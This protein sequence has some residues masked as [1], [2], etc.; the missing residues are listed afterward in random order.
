MRHRSGPSLLAVLTLALAASAAA[1]QQPPA[2][3]DAGAAPQADLG[4]INKQLTNPVSS[5]WSITFQQNNFRIDP[6]LGQEERWSSNLLFQPVLPIGITEEWNLVTRPVVP[7]FVSQPHPEGGDPTDVGRSTNFGDITLMQLVSPG[8]QLAGGWLLGLGPSWIF[9]SAGSNWTGSGRWQLGPAALAGYLSDKWILGA[10]LQN[11]WSFAGP[12]SR[13][14]VRSMNLQ[15]IASYFLPDA[16]S[17]GYS[18]NILANWNNAGSDTFTVPIGVSIA[19]VVK[20]GKLPVRFAL[21]GQWMPIQPDAYGQKWN[22]QLVVAPVL[23]KLV[24]G[25]LSEPSGMSFGLHEAAPR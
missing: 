19:K 5:L 11:W 25:Y 14:S 2:D 18:G 15:P 22:L 17:I 23:P 1:E 13:A 12:D 10:L 20:L 8:P 3:A 16:W 7:L 21:G 4:A 6:G 9:P 24:K